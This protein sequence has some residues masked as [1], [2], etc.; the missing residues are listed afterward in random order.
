VKFGAVLIAYP[1][2]VLLSR[3]FG[4]RTSTASWEVALAVGIGIAWGLQPGR[5]PEQKAELTP[6]SLVAFPL[7]LAMG[8]CARQPF[9][10]LFSATS[11][12]FGL[13]G[14]VN[15]SITLAGRVGSGREYT[16]FSAY[17]HSVLWILTG[18]ALTAVGFL[19]PGFWER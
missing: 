10:L 4:G 18:A 5:H 6:V 13:R 16:G 9:V 7:F 2:A 3:F 15:G 14:L 17:L 1:L 8:L 19:L 11:V 12:T